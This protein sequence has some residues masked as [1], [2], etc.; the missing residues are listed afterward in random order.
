ML[1]NY[2]KTAWRSLV[3]GKSF[4]VINISGLAIGMA[5]AVLILLWIQ[6]EVGFDRFHKNKDNLYELYVL[7]ANTDGHPSAVNYTSQPLGPALKHDFPEVESFSR[8]WYLNN[9]LIAYNNKSF[10]TTKGCFVD[11]AFLRM[12]TFPLVEG[13]PAEQFKNSSSIT[14]TQSLSKKLF[15]NDEP[16]GKVIKI[17]NTDNFTVTGVLKDPPANTLFDFDY[18]LPW[19]YHASVGDGF[20]NDRQRWMSNNTHTFVLL[21]PNTDVKAF[22][23]KIKDVAKHYTGRNDIWTHFVYPLS[24]LHL[25]SEFKD[26][27]PVGGRIDTVRVFAIIAIFILLIACINFV[28]LCTAQS[29]KRAKEVGIRKVAGAAKALLVGQFIV[30]AFV[31]ACIAGRACSCHCANGASVV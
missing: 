13:K 9:W 2:F 25:Y 12:F 21:K 27:K 3:R 22:N 19:S 5:G 11:T 4:S 6:N 31:T 30:E 14:I 26:G 20:E 17:E 28:N 15:G 29:E 10:T 18:L 8:V 23:A 7:T 24:R 1:K 16:I